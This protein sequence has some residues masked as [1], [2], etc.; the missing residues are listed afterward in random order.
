M[1]MVKPQVVRSASREARWPVL[2]PGKVKPAAF[3][4]GGDG[5]AAVEHGIGG[6]HFQQLQLTPHHRPLQPRGHV[7]LGEIG[8]VDFLVTAGPARSMAS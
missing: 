6:P 4:A 5:G 8:A 7:L 2:F 3:R 1:E